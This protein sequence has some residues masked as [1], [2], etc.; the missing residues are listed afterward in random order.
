LRVAA[1]DDDE[2]LSK[3]ALERLRQLPQ[4]AL[5]EPVR[6]RATR[7]NGDTGRTRILAV[8]RRPSG[9]GAP[10]AAADELRL[11][12]RDGGKARDRVEENAH[13]W[14]VPALIGRV[15]SELFVPQ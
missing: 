15:D 12:R 10:E 7:L 3:E 1:R 13:H 14:A 8:L 11:R 6:S 4:D 5:P 2:Q 9:P